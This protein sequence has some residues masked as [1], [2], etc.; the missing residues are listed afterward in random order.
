M[1][2]GGPWLAVP[3]VLSRQTGTYVARAEG[4]G[5]MRTPRLMWNVRSVVQGGLASALAIVGLVAFAS[6]SFA[7]N[8]LVSASGQ[9]NSPLGSG[10]TIT[11][12]IS[13]DYALSETGSVASVSGGTGT[14]PTT[15]FTIAATPNSQPPYSTTTLTQNL[16]AAQVASIG[17][18]DTLVIHSKWSDGYPS[19][20]PGYLVDSGTFAL[21]AHDCSAPTGKIA[22]HIYLCSSGNPTTTEEAGGTLS[23]TGPQTVGSSPNP[24][25]QTTVNAG[26]YTMTAT[27]PSGDLLVACGGGSSPNGSGTS[28]S[29]SVT[30]PSGGAGAGVF[31]VTPLA[32]KLS[33]VKASTRTSVWSV[34]TTIP[35]T[36]TV[37]NS[38]NVTLTAVHV[39]DDPVAPA[40]ALATGP[41]CTGLTVPS[42][43]CTSNSSTTLVPG[44]VAT[45]AGT[46]TVTQADLDHGSIADTSTVT[47]TNPASLGGTTTTESNDVTIIAAQNPSI[48]VVK[49][50]DVTTVSAIGQVVTDTFA[51]ANTGNVTLDNVDLTD[52]VG[53]PSIGSS[54][55]PLTCTTGSNGSI[56]LAPQATD[57]C[58]ATYTVTR[59]DLSHGSVADIATVVGTPPAPNGPVTD[60]ASLSLPVTSVSVVKSASP[61]SGVTAGSTVPIVYTMTVTNDGTATTTAPVVV[62]DSSPDGTTLIGDSPACVDGGTASCTGTV[63]GSTISWTIRAGVAP[64][65]SYTLTYAVTANPTDRTGSIT[66]TASWSGPS[67]G[68]PAPAT[69]L[70]NTVT[71]PVT[72]APVTGAAVTTIGMPPTDFP[73]IA[74]PAGTPP[75]APPVTTAAPATAAASAPTSD[76][77]TT[78]ALAFTGAL[79]SWEWMI[80]LV[81]LALGATMTAIARRRR[82]NAKGAT[83]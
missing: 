81:A 30:V 67:C 77:A 21:S 19:Q 11:W 4:R 18:T 38:G 1:D 52:A 24:L 33:I 8:N 15:A 69:C 51:I 59:A 14:L 79:L 55:G 2:T 3:F 45:F 23:A 70:T 60:S 34:G 47:G 50:A 37:T 75:Q 72:A 78:S 25:A 46:Y 65:T 31:Y 12:N 43:A 41:D 42:A 54:L 71:T 62:T 58:T 26:G 22:G 61:N 7:H 73:P 40:G 32:P 82:R 83:T 16:S 56:T 27:P 74:I 20:S 49:T 39:I 53:L 29:E 68:A 63:N 10:I 57:T 28:A 64:G 9:C 36:F 6:P 48:S 44:Q 17:S 13:N 5:G 35:Y 66:N 76:P 80:G